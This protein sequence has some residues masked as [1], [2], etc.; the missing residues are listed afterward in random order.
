MEMATYE[1]SRYVAQIEHWAFRE[2]HGPGVSVPY[3]GIYRCISCGHEIALA[4][5]DMTPSE[6]HSRHRAEIPIQWQLLVA[7]EPDLGP[8]RVGA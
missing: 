7:H 8:G 2:I 1:D 5:A 4:P 6:N 3:G